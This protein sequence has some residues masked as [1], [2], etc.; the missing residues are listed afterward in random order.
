M[1]LMLEQILMDFEKKN[2]DMIEKLKVSSDYFEIFDLKE[3]DE[4]KLKKSPLNQL[5]S[6]CNKILVIL[7]VLL[8]NFN[9]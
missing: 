7:L 4:K 6:L 2:L 5:V 3:L 1:L 8:K 9:F